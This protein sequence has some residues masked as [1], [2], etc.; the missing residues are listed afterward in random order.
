MIK[1]RWMNASFLFVIINYQYTVDLGQVRVAERP[2][3]LQYFI[4]SDSKI[5]LIVNHISVLE[6]R[7]CG[8]M[9]FKN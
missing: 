8:K 9:C 2:H 1:A 7:K 3:Q 5:Q 4:D 6:I